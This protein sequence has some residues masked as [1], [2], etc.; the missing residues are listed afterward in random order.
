MLPVAA[1]STPPTAG[2]PEIS[3]PLTVSRRR[4]AQGSVLAFI[5][6]MLS[7][8]SWWNDHFVNVPIALVLAWSVALF[9]PAGFATSFVIAYWLTNVAGLWLLHLGVRRM[10]TTETVVKPGVLRKTLLVSLLYTVLLIALVQW[11][12]LQPPPAYFGR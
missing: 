12:L 1:A 2:R 3:A 6:F 8:L 4:R 10:S 9:W 7:P 5:G 11:R